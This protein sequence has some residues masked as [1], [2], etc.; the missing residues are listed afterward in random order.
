MNAGKRSLIKYFKGN[1]ILKPLMGGEK[2]GGILIPEKSR[3][4]VNEGIVHSCS[5]TA[6]V[7]E[8]EHVIYESYAGFEI[9]VGDEV[10]I[11]VPEEDIIATR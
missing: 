8:G 6:S 5:F 9:K 7:T 4:K 2:I 11:I 10:F 1:V 3:I